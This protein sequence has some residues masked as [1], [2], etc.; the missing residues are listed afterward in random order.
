M[1]RRRSRSRKRPSKHKVLNVSVAKELIKSG[2]PI[3]ILYTKNKDKYSRLG[4][5]KFTPHI[6]E[7]SRGKGRPKVRSNLLKNW[8]INGSGPYIKGKKITKTKTYYVQGTLSDSE[9]GKKNQ[10]WPLQIC[11][12]PLNGLSH[13][14]KSGSRLYT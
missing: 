5:Y 7:I 8:L 3:V 14:C 12:K 13:H 1:G 10:P 4:K 2:K 6:S 11:S 9:F